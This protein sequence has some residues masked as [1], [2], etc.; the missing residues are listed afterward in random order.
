[1][2]V[3]VFAPLPNGV[4]LALQQ[5]KPKHGAISDPATIQYSP[6]KQ[7]EQSAAAKLPKHTAEIE[8]AHIRTPCKPVRSLRL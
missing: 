1:M 4:M 5:K 2:L 7:P 6:Q 8:I 3:L